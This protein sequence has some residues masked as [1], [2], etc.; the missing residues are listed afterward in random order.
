MELRREAYDYIRKKLSRLSVDVSH[1]ESKPVISL[2]ELT[3]AQGRNGGSVR[4][5]CG[6]TK[7]LAQWYGE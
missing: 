7:A 1:D 4:F 6:G 3:T 2:D 5:A